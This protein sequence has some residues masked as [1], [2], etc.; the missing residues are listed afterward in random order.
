[1]TATPRRGHLPDEQRHRATLDIALPLFRGTTNSQPS[2]VAR[3]LDELEVPIGARV[4][5]IGAGSGWTTALL[6]WLVGPTGSVLGLEIDPIV[7]AWGSERL[8]RTGRPWATLEVADPSVLGRPGE[9]P[10]D[11]ILVSAM[12]SQLP[13]ALL[14]QLADGGVLVIP[15]DG[16]LCT[17]RRSGALLDITRSGAYVFVPLLEPPDGPARSKM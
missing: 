15:V 7:A 8:R 5:D 14:S 10:F 17:V 3:M 12:A 11:R 1:M 9:A 6:A 4:L 16:R 13:E 2:T